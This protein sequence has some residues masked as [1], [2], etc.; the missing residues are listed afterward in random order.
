MH[1]KWRSKKFVWAADMAQY[2]RQFAK[3]NRL[4]VVTTRRV[5]D[6][7]RLTFPDRKLP[8]ISKI[9]AFLKMRLDSLNWRKMTP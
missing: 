4:H 1:C 7:L 9:W 6:A 3:Q 5:R 8:S 2:V